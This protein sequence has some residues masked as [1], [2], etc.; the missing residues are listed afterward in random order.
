MSY[1]VTAPDLKDVTYNV[2]LAGFTVVSPTD[3]VAQ[4]ATPTTASR[5][6]LNLGKND[7]LD[8]ADFPF[9]GINLLSD[10]ETF[11]HIGDSLADELVGI[12]GDVYAG[13]SA[14][15]QQHVEVK[16]WCRNGDERDRL[17]GLL[18]VVLFAGRGTDVNPGLFLTTDGIVLPKITGGVDEGISITGEQY[19]AHTVYTRTYFVTAVTELTLQENAS[20]ALNAVSVSGNYYPAVLDLPLA[21]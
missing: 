19:P 13:C 1:I 11:T 2:L 20:S 17:G 8:W 18:K 4:P 12:E 7:P 10:S 16:L 9:I 6:A 21:P 3:L 14:L 5:A 15:F